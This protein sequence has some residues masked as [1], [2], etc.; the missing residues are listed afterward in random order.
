M[1]FGQNIGFERESK[2]MSHPP[3]FILVGS[4]GKEA[5]PSMIALL[6]LEILYLLDLART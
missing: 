5:T 4:R 3:H 1:H 6:K 2:S